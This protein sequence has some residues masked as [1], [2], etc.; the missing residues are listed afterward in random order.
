MFHDVLKHQTFSKICGSFVRHIGKKYNNKITVGEYIVERFIDKKIN[1]GYSSKN[2]M[3]TPFFNITNKYN[4]FNVIFNGYEE[5]SGHCAL[6]Y[7]KH[8]NN[9]GLIL[10]TS[11]CGFT[12]IYKA[13]KKAYNNNIPLLLMSFYDK[14][15]ESKLPKLMKYEK[16]YLKETYNVNKYEECSNA[17]EYMMMVSELP[18]QGPVHLN[19]CSS[20]LKRNIDLDKLSLKN[21]ISLIDEGSLTQNRLPDSE[22]LSLLQYYEKKYEEIEK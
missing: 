7:A 12:N 21:D 14:N 3:Y 9:I 5:T 19:I 1:I 13:L 10:T 11:T 22:E 17:L 20:F 16:Q 8:T 2:N 6:I 4:N 18:K 15:F